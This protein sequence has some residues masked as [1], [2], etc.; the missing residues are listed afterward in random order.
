MQSESVICTVL[1]DG[2][3]TMD[4]RSFGIVGL[5]VMGENLALNIEA[6]EFL[7]GRL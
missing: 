3:L 5:G 6:E 4:K 1:T 7:R 2:E